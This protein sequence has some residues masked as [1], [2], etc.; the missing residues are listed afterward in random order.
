MSLDLSSQTQ[1]FH[2][3]PC[4]LGTRRQF[5]R[6]HTAFSAPHIQSS[7]YNAYKHNLFHIWNSL[8]WSF[9]P[10]R[11]SIQS[12][13]CENCA[14][15]KASEKFDSHFIKSCSLISFLALSLWSYSN[16]QNHHYLGEKKLF[17]RL[18]HCWKHLLMS[19]RLNIKISADKLVAPGVRSDK[20]TSLV[21]EKFLLEVEFLD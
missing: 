12:R 14:D 18:I 21:G 6:L 19:W 13:S 10:Q 1:S 11:F 15:E 4:N 2:H 5:L 8:E 9:C 3:S 7:F 17:W 16:K 20:T